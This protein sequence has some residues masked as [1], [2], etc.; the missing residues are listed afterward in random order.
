MILIFGYLND[1]APAGP[2]GHLEYG[3]TFKAEFAIIMSYSRK[4]PET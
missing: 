2:L 3:I 4:K 1:I